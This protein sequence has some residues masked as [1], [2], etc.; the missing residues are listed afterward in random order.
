MF[1]LACLFLSVSNAVL[2]AWHNALAEFL[3]VSITLPLVVLLIGSVVLRR[4]ARVHVQIDSQLRQAAL[5]GSL[6]GSLFRLPDSDPAAI[7]WNRILEQLEDQ[8]M[9]N[10]LDARLCGAWGSVGQQR[11][12]DVFNTLCDGIAICDASGIIQQAN[13]AFAALMN[14]SSAAMVEGQ[15]LL[16]CI[17]GLR[18]GEHADDL[19][20]FGNHSSLTR[21]LLLG[22]DVAAGVLRVSR[23]PLVG[24]SFCPNAALWTIR[25]VTQQKLAEE[26]RNQFLSTATHELRTPLTTIM[27]Y[28]E[29]LAQEEDL[30]V[31]K[32]KTFC[33][34]I[35]GEA[36]RLARFVD[37]LLNVNQM[38]AGALSLSRHETDIERLVGEVIENIQPQ[39]EQKPLTFDSAI[40]AKLP[41]LS[42][43]K[44]KLSAALIN[45]LGNAIKYTPAQG[46]VKLTV[47]VTAEQMLFHVE[48]TGIG[49]SAEELPRISEKFFRSGDARVRSITGSGLGLAFSQEIARLHGGRI[50][51]TS[52]LNKGSRF[53]LALPLQQI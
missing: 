18:Q 1:G 20:D 49:I 15:E 27:A 32:Q 37:Q 3:A 25:N 19:D 21:D 44:D 35:N 53:T 46:H 23:I 5:T 9:G 45:L 48:D 24:D 42:V 14:V 43:D 12:S 36:T 17:A 29:L 51:V 52:E 28:A 31:E 50:S 34:T 10:D 22:D 7:A 30:D 47:E 4:T 8:Q 13:N 11:W 6:D 26:M 2:L 33:N 39:T 38:E 41:K 40:P 16:S